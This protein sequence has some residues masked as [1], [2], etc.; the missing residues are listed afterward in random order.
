MK[1]VTLLGDSIRQRGYGKRV[2]EMLGNE[3]EVFPY[4]LFY[5]KISA[6]ESVYW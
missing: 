3:Y 6:S 1:K 4:H 2:P 5:E